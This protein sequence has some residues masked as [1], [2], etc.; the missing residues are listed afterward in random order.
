M[1]GSYYVSAIGTA[2]LEKADG[3]CQDYSAVKHISDRLVVAAIADGLGS[4]AQSDVGAKLAVES[5]I[6]YISQRINSV[7]LNQYPELIK[8]AYIYAYNETLSKAKENGI[9]ARDYNTTLTAVIYCGTEL[10]YGQCGDG[11]IIA[12]TAQGDYVRVTSAEKGESFNETHP[13]LNGEQYWSFDRFQGQVCAFLMM[14]DG[15]F[16]L[17]CSPLLNEQPCPIFVAFAR[18]FIDR[19]ILAANNAEDFEK[20]QSRISA[21]IASEKFSKDYGVTDDKTIVGVINTGIMPALK[22]EKYYEAPDWEALH[23]NMAQKIYNPPRKPRVEPVEPV[24]VQENAVTDYKTLFEEQEQKNAELENMVTQLKNAAAHERARIQDKDKRL[25]VYGVIILAELVVIII[26]GLLF[27]FKSGSKD[28]D[29]SVSKMP[30]VSSVTQKTT[31]TQKT[32]KPTGNDS[33]AETTTTTT[34]KQATTTTTTTSDTTT[35]NDPNNDPNNNPNNDPNNDPNNNLNN[36]PNNDP[37][38]N[39]NN[40]PNNNL[41][42]DPNNNLN[43]NPNNDLNNDPNNDLNN[44]P[45]HYVVHKTFN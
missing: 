28:T 25:L 8:Q 2:H 5:V 16:D 41:N 35:G 18:K 32:T 33:K 44:D 34:T 12:L 19:N 24:I 36:N 38:N 29:D 20:L 13:L 26:L 40:D 37:N 27:I 42:N 39:P 10:Y 3:V 14:T 30:V 4:A 43:N 6:E 31:N 9:D 17:V 45:N 11:G 15:I 22:D 1:I 7:P 23:R 21:F